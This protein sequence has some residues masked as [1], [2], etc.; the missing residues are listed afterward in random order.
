MEDAVDAKNIQ[1]LYRHDKGYHAFLCLIDK[2][3]CM[4]ST[5][6]IIST[7]TPWYIYNIIAIWIICSKHPDL[8][9]GITNS[10]P[11]LAVYTLSLPDLFNDGRI[12]VA[13]SKYDLCFSKQSIQKIRIARQRQRVI[14]VD[15]LQKTA[16][17]FISSNVHVEPPLDVAVPVSAHWASTARFLRQN[18]H[19]EET[20]RDA[21]LILELYPDHHPQGQGGSTMSPQDLA[22][23]IE[24]TSGILIV[25]ERYS[26]IL[27]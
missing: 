10:E 15:S 13:I 7:L 3:K 11:L 23:N 25:E 1:Q 9:S 6:I 12:V 27:Y 26:C 16:Q 19:D 8:C 4:Y 14:T 22:S 2:H 17:S 18:P 20:L 5:H 24:S 21:R